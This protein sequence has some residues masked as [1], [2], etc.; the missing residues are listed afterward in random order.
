MAY[1]DELSPIDFE[2]FTADLLTEVTGLEFRAG[3]GGRDKGIDL[4]A[5]VDGER[6]V[7]QCKHFKDSTYPQLRSAARKEAKQLAERESEFASYRFVTSRRLNHDQRKEIAGILDPWVGS[8]KDVYGEGDLRR[9]LKKH[10]EVER[11][12]VKLWLRS[13]GQLR[14]SLSAAS[15]ER[16]RALMEE[17]RRQLPRYVQTEA[18]AKARQMLEEERVCV[19]A[20]PAGI[21]KTTLARLLLLDGI[22]AGYQPFEIVSGGLRDVWELLEL[23][24]QQIFYFD[25]FLGR[26]AL[27][28]SRE[29]DQ[30]LVR[31]LRRIAQDPKRRIVLTTREYI[32]AQAHR[33]SETLD[34]ETAASQ[35]YLL[36]VGQYTRC[37]EARIFYNHVYFSPNLDAAAKESLVA[38]RRYREVVDHPNY[39]PRLIEW[40]TGLSMHTVTEEE[41]NDYATYCLNVLNAPDRLWSHTFERGLKDHERA[42]LISFLGLPPRVDVEVA[43]IAFEAACEARGLSLAGRQ[44]THALSVLDDSLIASDEEQLRLINPSLIDFLKMYLNTSPADMTAALR[45]A[46]FFDQA[47]WVWDSTREDD[48]RP[49]ERL[50]REFHDAFLRLIER[51]VSERALFDSQTRLG[52]RIDTVADLLEE[53]SWRESVATWLPPFAQRWLEEF[54]E[55]QDPHPRELPLLLKLLEY[56]ILDGEQAGPIAKE[57]VVELDDGLTRWE[58]LSY[59]CRIRPDLFSKQEKRQSKAGLEGFIDAVLEFRVD[60]RNLLIAD[61]DDLIQAADFWGAAL[62]P[63]LVEAH[64][65]VVKESEDRE[66][67]WGTADEKEDEE[68]ANAEWRSQREYEAK[69]KGTLTPDQEDIFI[70]SMF[71]RLISE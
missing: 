45:C 54:V 59:L 60:S 20:G 40:M 39:N 50:W 57:K 64:R 51:P 13:V 70:D 2:E 63:D 3:T 67:R 55:L 38:E 27:F 47:K 9:H 19:I 15:Y 14:Q 6:H 69:M 65:T 10:P 18:F 49:P 56:E 17:T 16:S 7:V 23:D 36:T 42:L 46:C 43:E 61:L 11:R 29:Q 48:R 28:E 24:E 5:I 66:E 68:Q 33:V 35:R 8:V 52:A 21:G 34:L 1:F 62:H 58:Y 53:S 44:F 25:D 26:T 4:E 31:F 22:E 71:M 41:E 30:D 12:N 32:L 37:E